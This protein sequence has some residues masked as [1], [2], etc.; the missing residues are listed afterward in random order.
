MWSNKKETDDDGLDQ[1]NR[2]GESAKEKKDYDTYA[3]TQ[4]LEGSKYGS[5]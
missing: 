4:T 3:V 5:S 1:K 2:G